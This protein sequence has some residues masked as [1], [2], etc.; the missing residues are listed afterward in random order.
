MPLGRQEPTVT[1]RLDLLASARGGRSLRA[2]PILKSESAHASEFSRIVRHDLQPSPQGTGRKQQVIG[3]YGRT[4][5]VQTCAQ[6]RRYAGIFALEWQDGDRTQ[7]KPH[8]L[9]H[10]R[11]E[12]GIARQSVLDFHLRNHRNS[13]LR[14]RFL[15]KPRHYDLFAARKVA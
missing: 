12:L 15:A 10:A 6:L 13:Q 1:G 2:V 5:T 8:C 11:C 3:S 4:L 7:K 14:R 9:P